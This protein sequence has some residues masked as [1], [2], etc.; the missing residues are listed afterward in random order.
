MIFLDVLTDITMNFSYE[1]YKTDL[2]LHGIC[3]NMQ[4]SYKSENSVTRMPQNNSS[5]A[6]SKPED[7]WSCKRS[8][9][10]LA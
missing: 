9:D 10:I 5:Y 2:S 1:D 8:P 6:I 4:C 7:Q 3:F